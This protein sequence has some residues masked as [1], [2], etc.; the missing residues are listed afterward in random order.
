[1]D[2][3]SKY[4]GFKL[5]YNSYLTIIFINYLILNVIKETIQKENV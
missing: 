1:M 4:L 3:N 5:I 2:D